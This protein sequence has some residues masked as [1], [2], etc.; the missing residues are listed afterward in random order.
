[1]THIAHAD[2]VGRLPAITFKPH[3]DAIT[4]IR[5]LGSQRDREV[6]QYFLTTSRDGSYKALQWSRE[7]IS[8][9]H[10][11]YPPIGPRMEGALIHAQNQRLILY[12]FRGNHF[13]LYDDQADREVASVDS[14]GGHRLW[15]F[16][17]S[18][19]PN[20]NIDQGHFAWNTNGKLNVCSIHRNMQSTILP[21]GHGREIK[22]CAVTACREL[23]DSSSYLVATGAEDTTIRIFRYSPKDVYENGFQCLRVIRKHN[24]GI[25]Q[26]LWS[27][28]GRYLLS[29]GGSEEVFVWQISFVPMATIGVRLSASIERLDANKPDLRVTGID[30]VEARKA[31]VGLIAIALSDSTVRLYRCDALG[32]VMRL[33]WRGTHSTCSLTQ[34]SLRRSVMPAAERALGHEDC[35]YVLATATDGS[36][37]QWTV[38]DSVH[39]QILSA[40]TVQPTAAEQDAYEASEVPDASTWTKRIQQ[41]AIKSLLDINLPHLPGVHL[42]VT[43]G[44]DNSLALTLITDVP[45]HT[46]RIPRAHA[47]SITSLAI[48]RGP[49]AL[50][51]PD[52]SGSIG[53]RVASSGNDMRIKLWDISIQ[54]KSEQ[55]AADAKFDIRKASKARTQIP[56]VGCMTVIGGASDGWRRLLLVGVGLEVVWVRCGPDQRVSE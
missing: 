15:S 45:L 29:C 14:K 16:V 31:E 7:A 52:G 48:I 22:A 56:D 38:R 24:T 25:Q 10:E 33:V 34:V 11:S 53:I 6:D 32:G 13:V 35:Y 46:L 8:I 42:T 44:D 1:M 19:P 27:S 37:N 4:S 17:A 47:A 3:Q 43:A 54:V 5:H 21:G 26:L 23:L 12:G 40:R 51:S 50:K 9:V 20:G 49:D 55:S 39:R 30:I 41:N 28:C 2:N 36:L 18:T